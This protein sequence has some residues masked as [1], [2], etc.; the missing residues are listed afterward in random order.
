MSDFNNLFDVFKIT[1]ISNQY[2]I[3]S[4]ITTHPN[5]L[6][7]LTYAI[8]SGGESGSKL[9]QFI[10]FSLAVH[11]IPEGLAVA[12]VLTSRKVSNLRAG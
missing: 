9:G 11:N 12:L 6:I 1:S 4:P 10:S 2:D 5:T 7:P 8:P 3:T